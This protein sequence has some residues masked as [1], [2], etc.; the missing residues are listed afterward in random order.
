MRMLVLSLSQR[1]GG[2][3]TG[4]LAVCK[5][6]LTFGETSA[7]NRMVR[8]VCEGLVVSSLDMFL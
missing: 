5:C 3:Q 2:R 7:G 1:S 4:R 8:E 6:V